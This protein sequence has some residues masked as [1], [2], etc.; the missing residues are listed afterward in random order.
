LARAFSDEVT[1]AAAAYEEAVTLLRQTGVTTLEAMALAELGDARL[2]MDE[3]AAAVPLLDEALILLRRTESPVG[4]AVTLGERAHAARMQ[5]DQAQASDL[6]AESIAVATEIGSERLILGAVAGL[7]GVALALG[8]PER[9][10]RM[11]SAVEVIRATS[12]LGR[13][14]HAAHT[15][16]ILAAARTSLAEPVFIAAWDEGQHLSFADAVAE[17][18]AIATSAGQKPQTAP[19]DVS[20]FRLTAR[21][22][23]VLRLVV[24]GHSDRQ[25]GEALFIGA[26]TVQTHVAN[27]FAKLGVNTRAEAAAVAVRQGLV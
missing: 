1:R 22:V 6:F 16:R 23:E 13:I 11:L 15:A 24:E 7:A 18:R 9:A 12:G 10:V 25:I 14:P 3:V 4:I 20:G 2:L 17:A 5:G 19:D 26:R 21:E 8:Q 27:L